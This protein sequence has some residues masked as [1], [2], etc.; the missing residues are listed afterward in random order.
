M[1]GREDGEP[2]AA[3]APRMPPLRAPELIDALSDGGVDYVIIGG[4]SLAAHGVVRATKD[5]DIVPDPTRANLTRLATVL[6]ALDAEHYD[7]GDFTP[8][9][10]PVQPGLAGL[11]AG[12]NCVLRTRLGRLDVMQEVKSVESYDELRRNAV[13]L[14]VPG[15][16]QACYFAGFEDLV[17]MKAAAGRPQDEIDIGTL[18]VARGG[19]GPSD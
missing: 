19:L 15:T 14:Q 17:R 4:F 5:L 10:F 11:R 3:D 12:G 1:S 8:E 2:N 16:K 7:L 13:S 18:K 6:N 9:Q